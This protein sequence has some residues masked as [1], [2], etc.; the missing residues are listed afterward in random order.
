MTNSIL[1]EIKKTEAAALEALQLASE[2]ADAKVRA[3][4]TEADAKVRDIADKLSV[5][6][7]A[8]IDTFQKE[9]EKKY[10]YLIEEA[11]GEA[12]KISQSFQHKR[13]DINALIIKMITA[14]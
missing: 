7:K 3:A 4:Q 2:E 12:S 1:D 10:Q 14:N 13:Q 5:S 8:N 11:E 6:A 9:I